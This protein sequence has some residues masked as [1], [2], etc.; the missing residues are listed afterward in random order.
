MKA[1]LFFGSLLLL[2]SAPLL[3]DQPLLKQPGRWAQ[4]YTGRK[5]D[6]RVRFGTLPNGLR[7]AIMH[8][9]TPT[10]GVAMRLHLGSGAL[11]ER[12]EEQGLAHFLEHMSFRGSK[13][14]ADGEVVHMLER[15]GLQFG[16][17]TNA[18][19]A[20][21]QTVYMFNFPKADATAVDTGLK[22]FREIGERLKLDPAAIEVEKGVVLSEERLSDT[23]QLRTVKANFA[24]VLDGTRVPSRFPIGTVETIKAATHD[25]LERYYRANYRP[26]NATIVVVGNI[27]ANVIEQKIKAGFSDWKAAGKPDPIDLGTP[28]G[29]KQIAEHVEAGAPDQLGIT[30]VAP[31]DNRAETEAVDRESLVR[32]V[33][34][35]VLNQRFA[36]RA[37]KPGS[38]FL[39]AQAMHVPAIFRSA[40][41]TQIGLAAAPEKWREALDSVSAEQRMLLR[42]GAQPGELQRAI[43][44]V[45]TQF[46]TK[47]ASASTRKSADI[48][49]EIVGVVNSD[50]LDTSEAQDLTFVTPL[51]DKLTAAEVDAELKSLFATRGPILFR[52]AQQ[53][54]AG[55]TQLASALGSAYSGVLAAQVKEAAISWPYTSFGKPSSIV[56]RSEDAKLGVTTVR[57]A[58]GTR[59]WVKPMKYEKDK[60]NVSVAFGSGR[61]AVAPQLTRALWQ[62]QFFPLVGTGK[63]SMGDI[64]KWTQSDGKVMSVGLQA[65]NRAFVLQGSTR[66]ADLAAQMQMLAAYA[67]DPGFRPEAVE[68]TKSIAPMFNGQLETNAGAVYFRGVEALTVGNDPRFLTMPSASDL[69]HVDAADLPT[70]LKAPLSGAADVVIVGDVT[71]PAAI[72]ATQN[73]F[74]AGPARDSATSPA[75]KVTMSKAADATVFEHK[76]RSDQ[77]FYGEYYPLPDYLA[78]P[79]VDAVADVLSHVLSTRMVDTV[80]E[81]L[82]ITYSPMVW[83]FSSADVRGAGYFTAAIETPQKN[84]DAFHAL[85][86]QQLDDLA[87]KPVTADELARAKQPLIESHRKQIET[88]GYWLEVLTGSTREPRVGDQAATRL[89]RLQAV[90]AVDIQALA[91]KHLAGKQPLIAISKAAPGQSAGAA[92]VAPSA[93]H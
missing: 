2:S 13:N 78:D 38:P 79:K 57:F 17:D 61:A 23:P 88:N 29:K 82:G 12:D 1:H 70:L 93:V 51:L 72:T 9:E 32:Q 19:T 89:G 15:Q 64:Q 10:D 91:L 5:A 49:N 20:H 24:A 65:R 34:L 28:T 36:D 31:Y 11:Q 26:E 92:G 66:P 44:S 3:A 77:A 55:E 69:Q 8:N 41:F 50:Q 53:G 80:R 84:F 21:D 76:G 4:D 75:P 37:S 86:K 22:L 42:D 35:A 40:S 63:L 47:A 56:S 85:L 58:N 7:Y 45:R 39:G 14:I 62:T 74:A 30:W 90:T 18:F 25:R 81:K 48:A 54:A 46:Q 73:T 87:T 6:P 83:S 52:S 27:D 43:T 60:I 16:P 59:L 68:K 33:A 67:R 71:V